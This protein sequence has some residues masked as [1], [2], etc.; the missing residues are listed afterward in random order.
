MNS[1]LQLQSYISLGNMYDLVGGNNF[2]FR[3]IKFKSYIIV[4]SDN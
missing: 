1:F 2:H 3:N 4:D